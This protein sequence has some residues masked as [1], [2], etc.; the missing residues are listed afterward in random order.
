M[1]DQMNDDPNAPTDETR[2]PDV[3]VIVRLLEEYS[4][5]LHT[6]VEQT[7]KTKFVAS[8]VFVVCALASIFTF[9][10]INSLPVADQGKNNT[11]LYWLAAL[12]P[13]LSGLITVFQFNARLA[14]ERQAIDRMA[15]AMETL[16]RRASQVED[17]GKVD[18]DKRLLLDL[19]LAEAESEFTFAMSSR[20]S[21]IR[22]LI[23]ILQGR[24]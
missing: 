24:F 13:I 20:R 19:R 9:F 6:R 12:L 1:I 15:R 3:D 2:L 14:R 4:E 23:R 11:T 16:M 18:F 5:K 21:V 7:L 17:H 8:A 10:Y 22:K